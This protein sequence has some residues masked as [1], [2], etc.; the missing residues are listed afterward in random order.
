MKKIGEYVKWYVYITTSILMVVALIFGLYGAEELPGETLW[1]ILVSGFA[2][3]LLTVVMVY[4]DTATVMGSV[5][6]FVGHYL[7]LCA[8]MIVLGG[9]FGWLNLNVRGIAMMMCAVAAVYVLAFGAYY[10]IDLRSAK[11]INRRLKEKYG[12]E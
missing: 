2:T 6:K 8:T 12:D 9:R 11:Q 4:V 10:I 1:Q 7:A 5:F 3:T